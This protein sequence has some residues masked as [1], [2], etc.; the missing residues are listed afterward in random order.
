MRKLFIVSTVALMASSVAFAQ[1][2][3]DKK[4]PMRKYDGQGMRHMMKDADTNQDG[5]LTRE[6]ADVAKKVMFDKIDADKDGSISEAE[7]KTHHEKMMAER[8]EN[9]AQHKEMMA[10]REENRAQH[11]EMMAKRQAKMEGEKQSR[12]DEHFSK[13]DKDGNGGI[14]FDEF[15]YPD[16][17]DMFSR[18][19]T[20]GD[21]RIT[22]E[23]HDAGGKG[24]REHMHKM[25]KAD[26]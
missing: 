13:M 21:G 26:E 12:V 19:D 6:E 23:E 4:M 3:D 10:E 20:D 22:K 11:Q 17:K 18:L 5:V 15:G 9:R 2:S 25:Q 7:M 14:S 1:D 24:M 8:E 16:E